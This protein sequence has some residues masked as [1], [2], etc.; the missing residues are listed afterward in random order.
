MIYH[1]VTPDEWHTGPDRPYA[2]ASLA[3]E[4]FVHCSP[5][6][7]TTVAVVNAFYRTAPRPLLALVLDETRLT[8][9]CTWEPADPAPPPGVPEGTLFPHVYGPLDRDAVTGIVEVQWDKDGRATGLRDTA[10]GV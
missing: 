1:V 8:A 2:P 4:G 6:P 5:D 10:T 3:Q 9:R 7:V